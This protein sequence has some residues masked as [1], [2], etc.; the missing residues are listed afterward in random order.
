MDERWKGRI[1]RDASPNGG[2]VT[3]YFDSPS[4]VSESLSIVSIPGDRTTGRET[5]GCPVCSRQ[6]PDRSKILA[7]IK[8][9]T[10]DNGESMSTV[11]P[12]LLIE[13]TECGF[14]RTASHDAEESPADVI[15]DHGRD[16]GHT[17][18]LERQKR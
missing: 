1:D 12:Q 14:R 7:R 2:D 8:K 16:T 9:F 15:I 10:T 13:C 4:R 17:V 18:T 6:F 5:L 11:E 3:R